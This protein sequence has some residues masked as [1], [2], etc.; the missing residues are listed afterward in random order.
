MNI[1]DLKSFHLTVGKK[2]VREKKIIS[3]CPILGSF[4]PPSISHIMM[5]LPVRLKYEIPLTAA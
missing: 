1:V 2:G 5:A 4:P 3:G